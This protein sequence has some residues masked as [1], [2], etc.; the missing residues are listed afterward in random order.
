MIP[1]GGSIRNATLQEQQK[2]SRTW[3]LDWEKGTVDGMTDGI[4]AV[5]Q[6]VY[7]MLRTERFQH[8]I[9]SF[10]YGSELESLIGKDPLLVQS[11]VNRMIKEALQQDD[12]IRDVQNVEVTIFGDSLLVKFDVV[13]IFG[14]FQDE[15]EVT[16]NV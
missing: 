10:N 4:E 9:Y 16:R 13:T 5:K 8:E 3:K 11:E 15:Q 6:A 2:P 14:T 1:K 7:L 12:R